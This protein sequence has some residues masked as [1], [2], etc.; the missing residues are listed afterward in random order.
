[1]YEVELEK[2]GCTRK[3]GKHGILKRH[4]KHMLLGLV[5][6]RT[7][8]NCE[9]ES[10]RAIHRNDDWVKRPFGEVFR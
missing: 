10:F 6:D 5:I 7:E 4:R 9:A 3:L 2:G 8:I 1:M